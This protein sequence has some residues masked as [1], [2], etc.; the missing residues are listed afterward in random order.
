M[1]G[2]GNVLIAVFLSMSGAPAPGVKT[3]PKY[4]PIAVRSES[5][6]GRF[7]IP[8]LPENLGS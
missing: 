4:E 3:D 1:V 7:Y 5:W 2:G 8:F 6:L